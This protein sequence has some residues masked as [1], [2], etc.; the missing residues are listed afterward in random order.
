[1]KLGRISLVIIALI[2]LT[3]YLSLFTVLE[4]KQAIVLQFG[5]PKKVITE[6]AK[7][8]VVTKQRIFYETME[9]VFGD[10]DKIIIDKNSGQGVLPYLPLPEINKKKAE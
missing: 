6:Y 7:A 5:D 1:M 4:V 8:P 3:A 9:S 10:M 2:G